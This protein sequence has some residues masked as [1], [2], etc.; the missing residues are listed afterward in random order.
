MLPGYQGH[1]IGRR[2]LQSSIQKAI[3]NNPHRVSL[4]LLV[5][6]HNPV[7]FSLYLSAGFITTQTVTGLIK[8]P[9]PIALALP[10]HLRF[11]IYK[12]LLIFWPDA[13]D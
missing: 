1:S 10:S 2:L 7:S 4:R 13:E 12:H 8:R 11:V 3:T 9:K 6:T 5:D